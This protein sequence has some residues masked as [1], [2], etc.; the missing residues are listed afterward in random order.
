MLLVSSSS[1]QMMARGQR[2]AAGRPNARSAAAMGRRPCSPCLALRSDRQQQQQQQH[3]SS[4]MGPSV[5]GE[6]GGGGSRRVRVAVVDS[7]V[8]RPAATG[9]SASGR[10]GPRSPSSLPLPA[11]SPPL[12][13]VDY[14]D[15]DTQ[16]QQAQVCSFGRC[17]LVVVV[18]VGGDKF[19][20]DRAAPALCL[21]VCVSLSLSLSLPHYSSLSLSS[22]TN[23]PCARRRTCSSRT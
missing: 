22:H 11:A 2:A 8:L 9:A 17:L 20:V 12:V 4:S 21:C 16:G 10:G 15:G 5:E 19:E 7:S 14:A 23:N 6:N 1:A 3:L 13:R 18:A